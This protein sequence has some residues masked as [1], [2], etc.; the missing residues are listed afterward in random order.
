MVSYGYVYLGNYFATGGTRVLTPWLSIRTRTLRMTLLETITTSMTATIR[1]VMSKYGLSNKPI[2]D[3]EGSWGNTSSGAITDLICGRL[4]GQ[5]LLL[6][7]VQW[8]NASTEVC[9]G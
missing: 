2:W 5:G 3:T 4:C 1:T 9:L 7:L 8:D 6:P